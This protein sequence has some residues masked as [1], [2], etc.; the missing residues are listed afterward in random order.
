MRSLI[1]S[2]I[3]VTFML[4]YNGYLLAVG[5]GL[6]IEMHIKKVCMY[7]LIGFF[8]LPLMLMGNSNKKSKMEIEFRNM[9]IMYYTV[10]LLII[11]INQFGV[12]NDPRKFIFTFNGLNI[13]LIGCLTISFLRHGYFRKS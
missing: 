5:N 9:A 4:G 3:A 12:L 11:V 8:T 6:L 10:V 2:L 1:T 7:S 13:A